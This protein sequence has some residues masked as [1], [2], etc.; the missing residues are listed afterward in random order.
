MKE[1]G[2]FYSWRAIDEA[3]GQLIK[4]IAISQSSNW[5]VYIGR[6]LAT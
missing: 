5:E 2:I 3:E 6:I 1:L 4:L